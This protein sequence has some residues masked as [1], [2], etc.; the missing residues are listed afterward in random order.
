MWFFLLLGGVD[1][2]EDAVSSAGVLF[3]MRIERDDLSE[4]LLLLR[5]KVRDRAFPGI[6]GLFYII[7]TPHIISFN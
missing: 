4:D 6:P 3:D 5:E 1:P 2:F 7:H